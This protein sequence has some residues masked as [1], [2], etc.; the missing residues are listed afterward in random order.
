[1]K[2]VKVRLAYQSDKPVN[3]RFGEVNITIAPSG[4]TA[5]EQHYA[6]KIIA[7]FPGWIEQVYNKKRAAKPKTI[8]TKE[9]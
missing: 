2:R 5:I 9:S 6:E 3:F 1:M 4:L 8:T 7:Q